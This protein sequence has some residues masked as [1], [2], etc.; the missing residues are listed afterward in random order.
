MAIESSV[1]A[2]DLE[3]EG[4]DVLQRVLNPVRFSS[5]LRK[6]VRKVNKK[7]GLAGQDILRQ[8]I[9]SANSWAVKNSP[10]T[11]VLKGSSKPLTDHG[12]LWGN[13]GHTLIGSFQ[14]VVGT[15]RVDKTGK[16]NIAWILHQGAHMPV[17]DGMR[18][19][20][21]YQSAKTKGKIKPLAAGTRVL[22]ISA[23]PFLK[24]AF[25][26]DKKFM[27]MCSVQ[28]RNALD[29]SFREGGRPGKGK[30]KKKSKGRP[31]YRFQAGGVGGGGKWVKK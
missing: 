9:G 31:G 29:K 19:F 11:Q 12:D 5:A 21:R 26:D 30:K 3:L 7:L 4:F 27:V 22:I 20:F 6:N 17:T 8:S 23:R 15:N 13:A 1:K 2:F 10:L 24:R 28:W 25:V 14:F 16:Y 18:R